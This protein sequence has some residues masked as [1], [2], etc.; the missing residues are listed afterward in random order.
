MKN[1]NQKK[2]RGLLFWVASFIIVILLASMLSDV[3]RGRVKELKFSEFMRMVENKQIDSA[4]IDGNVVNGKMRSDQT[5]KLLKYETI[6]PVDYPEFIS[7]LRKNRVNIEVEKINK[8]QF[9]SAILTWAP[10]LALII[11]WFIIMRQQSGGKAFSFGKSKARMF[12][13]GDKR[14]V[15]F[16]DVAGID[17][18]KDELHEIIEFLKEPK[19]FQRLGGKIPKGVLLI[20]APGTGKTLLA[21]AI[22][23]EA[24][25]PFFTISGSDFVELFVGV[26]ASRV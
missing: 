17:E 26:G 7:I 12:T 3:S 9:F 8:N 15:T 19:K 16:K 25:V 24:N 2:S 21:K 1:I 11:F 10:F 23:G 4:H 5:T 20:G 14:K 13:A 22:A 6:I 18:A